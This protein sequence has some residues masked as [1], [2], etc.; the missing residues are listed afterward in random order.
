MSIRSERELQVAEMRCLPVGLHDDRAGLGM[1][2]GFR[3]A[4][5][6]VAREQHVD[7]GYR[8]CEVNIGIDI[9]LQTRI[10]LGI[11]LHGRRLALVREQHD[12]IDVVTK[13]VDRAL[14]GFGRH[15]DI[16]RCDE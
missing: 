6:G 3:R 9:A 10:A 2:D 14:H 15:R 12:E 11:G 13:L 16:E 4:R 7:T 8:A 5:I 1:H